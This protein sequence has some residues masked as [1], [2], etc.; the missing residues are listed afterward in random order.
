MLQKWILP[1]SPAETERLERA[2]RMVRT[3]ISSHPA[4][5]GLDVSVGAKGSYANNTNVRYDSDVDIKVQLNDPYVH[6]YGPALNFWA[7]RL[8]NDYCGPWT[9]GHLRD[10]L[11][12]ALKAAFGDIDA[13]RNVAFYV[14]EVAGSRPSIDVVPCF[15][16]RQYRNADC[17]QWDEGSIVYTRDGGKIVNWPAQQLDNGRDKNR[18]TNRRYKFA[19]RALKAVENDLTRLGHLDALPSYF[20][21]CLI[22][23]VPDQVLVSDSLDAAFRSSLVHLRKDVHAFWGNW[24][25]M[26]E[27]NEMKKVFQ[28]GQKWKIQDARDLLE[29]AWHYLNYGIA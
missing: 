18:R 27:P 19:V 14:P 16:F 1:P 5:A 13:S 17:T 6:A 11:A 7:W 12:L 21:E 22:Y 25:A 10:E 3:A 23:N 29:A 26:W 24:R 2:E 8:R 20:M 28:D 4:F 9:P 15:A